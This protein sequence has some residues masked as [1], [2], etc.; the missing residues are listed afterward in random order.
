MTHQDIFAR[1][2][3]ILLYGGTAT[4]VLS[5]AGLVR[6]RRDP[7]RG[8]PLRPNRLDPVA[9]LMLFMFY[10][11][12]LSLFDVLAQKWMPDV[13]GDELS[14]ALR[15]AVVQPLVSL[16]CGL[17]CLIV[18]RRSFRAGLRG[19]GIGRR[20]VWRDVGFACV[21]LIAAWPAVFGLYELSVFV[22]EHVRPD[23]KPPT[24]GV[25]QLLHDAG[26]PAAAKAWL[27]AGAFIAAPFAEEA[28]FRGILQTFVRKIVRSR[29]AAILTIG[30]VFGLIHGAQPQAILPLTL[31][32][33][34]LGF[35]Y[36]RTGSL[37]CPMLIH[38]MFNGRTLLYQ[39]LGSSG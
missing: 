16:I 36:E 15:Q 24:H 27:I 37:V 13:P 1:C 5:L 35:A 4:L 12:T 11:F 19:F 30:L 7:L 38:A 29:W 22:L 3:Q 17:A 26:A 14:A 39:M 8:S 28:F 6:R 32:G 10:L 21:V 20:P 25:I 18:G 33:C 23:Y 9:V 34:V 2:D 31:L